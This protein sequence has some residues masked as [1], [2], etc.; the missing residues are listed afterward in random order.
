MTWFEDKP[1]VAVVLPFI[2]GMIFAYYVKMPQPWLWGCFAFALF[3]AF[4]AYWFSRSSLFVLIT[5]TALLCAGALIL[6]QHSQPRP[7]NDLCQFADLPLLT[8]IEGVICSPVDKQADKMTAV[9]QAD[10]AW[11]LGAG[12]PACGRCLVK[13]YKIIPDLEYGDRIVARGQ[14]RLPPEERNPGDFNYQRYLAAQNIYSIFKI[15][16][17]QHVLTLARGEGNRWFAAAVL[18][19]RRF[20]IEFI[21]RQIGGQAGALLKGL[22]LGARGDMDEEVKEA[23]AN[24]G[25]IHV[26]AVSGLNVGFVAA[27]LIGLLGFLRVPNPWRMFAAVVGLYGY[28]VLTG[29]NPPVFRAA[30]MSI[31]FL[32]GTLLQ[33]R[34]NI[35]NSLSVAAL[36]I[37][38]INPLQLFEV[39]FQLSFMAVLGTALFYRHFTQS[40]DKVLSDWQAKGRKLPAAIVSMLFVSL[41]A[42]LAT[43]PLTAYYFN[44][45]PLY[46]LP[47]NLVVVPAVEVIVILGFI[48]LLFAVIWQPLG[49]ILA[50]A[51][52]LWLSALIAFVAAVAKA[53]F[54]SLPVP[55]LS[56]VWMIIF[57]LLC[58]T[59]LFRRRQKIRNVLIISMLLLLNVQIWHDALSRERGLRITFFDVGQGDATL[60]QFP[61]GKTLLVDAGD[62]TEY[63]DCG[64]DLL[65]PYL[66]RFGIRR[67]NTLVLTHPHADHI[68]GAVSM[69][70]EM[71]I[72]RLVKTGVHSDDPFDGK[73]DSLCLAEN[74]PVRYVEAGDTLLIDPEVLLLVLHPTTR[75][76]Q[77]ASSAPAEINDC[78]VVLKC[79]FH[80]HSLLLAGDAETPAECEMC[81]YSDLLNSDVLKLGH[82]GSIT[83]GSESFRKLVRAQS[84][85]V[86]VA[87]F[88][89]FGLPSKKLL[90]DIQK[91]GTEVLRTDEHGAIQFVLARD[92]IRRLR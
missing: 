6:A 15:S 85:V 51:V 30:I 36:I 23:F 80:D 40:F 89:R 63:I 25:V 35:L 66:K 21:D 37:L 47:A 31:I 78:S 68:G 22:L 60:V 61:N 79:I 92:Q 24:V 62:C 18:P 45:L 67:I 32:V 14:L 43:L 59:F 53:P 42:Q 91:E 82:H 57:V 8:T 71:K 10:S 83:A 84:A 1:A 29:L 69:M 48:A 27:L 11:V 46:S 20:T 86:S 81:R 7:A 33:R 44:R 76:I 58:V 75:F 54:A 39:S 4:A 49:A 52:W 26:L 9:L 87:K 77:R 74:V 64:R 12:Y 50:G 28:A 34:T 90:V 16:S 72:G 3:G 56:L 65:T 2:G 19:I 5:A 41:A 73:I 38:T 17:A 88:N 70:Q 55:R 13:F